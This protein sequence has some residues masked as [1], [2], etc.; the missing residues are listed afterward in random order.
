MYFYRAKALGLDTSKV[1]NV[2]LSKGYVE[3]GTSASHKGLDFS[4]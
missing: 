1:K 2:I 3:Q 4:S